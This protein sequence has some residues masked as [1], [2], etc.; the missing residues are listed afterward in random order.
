M[1]SRLQSRIPVKLEG[2]LVSSGSSYKAFINN[3]SAHGLYM[4]VLPTETSSNSMND[5][6]IFLK[7]KLPHGEPINLNCTRK[8]SNRTQHGS[9]IDH[10]GVEVLVPP[11]QYK[12][13]F[14][15]MC[16]LFNAI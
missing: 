6:N 16:M 7:L 5:S 13:F 9:V 11:Q 10:M 4:K 12:E 8:W 15:S 2:E 14:W 3:I 1:A